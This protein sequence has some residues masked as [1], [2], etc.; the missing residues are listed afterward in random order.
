MAAEDYVGPPHHEKKFHKTHFQVDWNIKLKSRKNK[1]F[2]WVPIGA[3]RYKLVRKVN[4]GKE[5]ES[6]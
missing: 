2:V 5:K 1:K 6:N 3:G 4:N